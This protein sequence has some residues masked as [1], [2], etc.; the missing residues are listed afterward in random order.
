MTKVISLNPMELPDDGNLY[1]MHSPGAT[2]KA[3]GKWRCLNTIAQNIK[4]AEE[5][6]RRKAK[7]KE[8]L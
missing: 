3:P 2:S 5:H 1:F 7:N 6:N 4:R 8:M